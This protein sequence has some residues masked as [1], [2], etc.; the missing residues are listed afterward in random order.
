MI[1]INL[2]R[3][4]NFRWLPDA[5]FSQRESQLHTTHNYCN[6]IFI[7]LYKAVALLQKSYA[8]IFLIMFFK[9]TKMSVHYFSVS[10]SNER[11]G[12]RGTKQASGTWSAPSAG[13]K[14]EPASET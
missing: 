10:Y 13:I 1:T 14:E 11:R 5:K 7:T 2:L 12:F 6:V 8:F 9:I 4:S 3:Q